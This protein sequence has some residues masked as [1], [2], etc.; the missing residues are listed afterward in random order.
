MKRKQKERSKKY[1]QQLEVK[2][3]KEFRPFVTKVIGYL[4]NLY[5]SFIG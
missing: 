5:K 1:L 4:K 2:R 3:E